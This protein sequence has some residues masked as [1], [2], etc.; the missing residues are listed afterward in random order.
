MRFNDLADKV[1]SEMYKRHN[2]LC[3]DIPI[4][5]QQTK[6]E[7]DC[8]ETPT[9]NSSK[10]NTKLLKENFPFLHYNIDENLF[11]RIDFAQYP[12]TKIMNI[13]VKQKYVRYVND[14]E[15]CLTVEGYEKA[16]QNKVHRLIEYFNK[17][18]GIVNIITTGIS[19]LVSIF[20]LTKKA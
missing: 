12:L 15:V 11:K 7:V 10:Y 16:S 6:W 20:F 9:L 4:E 1:L 19:I 5:L 8:R 13:L 3:K 14:Y 18:P 17:N 2:S